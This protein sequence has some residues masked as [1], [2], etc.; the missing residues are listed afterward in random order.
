[1]LEKLDII[2]ARYEELGPII[3]DPEVIN[4]QEEWQ[5]LVKEHASL[6]EI[7]TRYREYKSINQEAQGAEELLEETEDGEFLQMIEQEL[8]ELNQKQETLLQEIRLLL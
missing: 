6:E 8:V 1:M 2:E 3:A 5:G 7:V 4:R